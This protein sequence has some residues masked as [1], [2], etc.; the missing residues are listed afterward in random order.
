MKIG[1][2]I[3]TMIGGGAERITLNLYNAFYE[4]GHDPYIFLVENKVE[5]DLSLIPADH[6]LWLSDTGVIVKNKML[7]KIILA[8]RLHLIVRRIEFRSSERFYFFISSAEDMDRISRIARLSNVYIRYRNSM[9]IYL[10]NKSRSSSKIKQ[11]YRFWRFRKKFRSIYGRRNI[12]TVSDDLQNDII[13]KVGVRPRTII[14]IYN[15]FNFELINQ[16]AMEQANIPSS[17][18]IISVARFQNRK[19]YDVLIK[20]YV[21]SNLDLKLVLMGGVYTKADRN[22][23]EYIHKLV[24]DY[25]ISDRVIFVGFNKNPYPWIKNASLFVLSSDSEGLPTVIIEA[26]ILGTPVVSTNCPTGPSEILTGEFSQYLSPVGDAQSLADNI[27][28]AL[29]FYPEINYD[30]ISKYHHI[31]VAKKYIKHAA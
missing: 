31:E 7:N 29:T 20:A 18:Y 9:W 21:I 26:L 30:L 6:L 19:R 2:L 14:T 8:W 17:N 27:V 12:I 25:G 13:E 11:Q 28:S 16:K 4:L 15:P 24:D 1:L 23:L 3:D 22:E 10:Q 5:H